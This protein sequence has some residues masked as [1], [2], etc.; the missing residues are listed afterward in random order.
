MW[1]VWELGGPHPNPPQDLGE[2][3]V[4]VLKGKKPT[5]VRGIEPPAE[6][7]EGLTPKG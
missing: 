1:S 4:R 5:L 7:W 6:V 2:G 3:T